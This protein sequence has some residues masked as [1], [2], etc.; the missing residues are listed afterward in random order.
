MRAQLN[1]GILKEYSDNTIISIGECTGEDTYEIIC[2]IPEDFQNEFFNYEA[3]IKEDKIIELK[4]T[5]NNII[6]V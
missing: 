1:N 4:N 6:F 2:D 5:K 3:E